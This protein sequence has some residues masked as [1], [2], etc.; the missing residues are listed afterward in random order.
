MIYVGQKNPMSLLVLA[1]AGISGA[2]YLIV[3][4]FQPNCCLNRSSNMA[5]CSG[6]EGVSACG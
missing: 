3:C 5:H 2:G 4:I 6:C 1:I